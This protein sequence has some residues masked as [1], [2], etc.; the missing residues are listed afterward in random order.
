MKFK[1]KRK[2]GKVF[3]KKCPVCGRRNG[4]IFTHDKCK[5]CNESLFLYEIKDVG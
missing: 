3:Y 2:S 5:F 4:Y 1:L